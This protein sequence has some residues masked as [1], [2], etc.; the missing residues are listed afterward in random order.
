MSPVVDA[1]VRL[2]PLTPATDPRLL[3]AV[4]ALDPGPDQERYCMP[5]A[6]TYPPASADPHRVPFAVV[7]R[8]QG[9]GPDSEVPVGFGVLDRRGHLEHLL[10]DPAK[11]L[12][13]RAFYVDR[14]HQGRG[15]GSAAARAARGL[16][17][18]VE[19]AAQLL[20][21]CVHTSNAAGL[22]AYAKAGFVDTG[23]RWQPRAADPQVV[24]AAALQPPTRRPPAR[25][26]PAR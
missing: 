12:L 19:P 14:A 16:A 7:R 2:E 9:G 3:A 21:L 10:D 23:G 26:P 18:A 6:R 24:M 1:P 8:A 20:V 22:R 15:Y 4:L 25:R 5:A 11:G 13:L 17:H